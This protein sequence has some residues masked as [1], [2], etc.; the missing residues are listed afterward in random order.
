MVIPA[1]SFVQIG[2]S[3]IGQPECIASKNTVAF[4]RS[5]QWSMDS[6][7][8]CSRFPMRCPARSPLARTRP[9]RALHRSEG[10]KQLKETLLKKCG[11]YRK[12]IVKVFVSAGRNSGDLTNRRD[13]T[14]T[15]AASRSTNFARTHLF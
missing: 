15:Y 2:D 14:K 5:C 8:S 10:R 11:L 3:R 6:F 13:S 7:G 4:A 12:V 1:I 9:L